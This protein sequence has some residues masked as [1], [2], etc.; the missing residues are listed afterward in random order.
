MSLLEPFR[1][2]WIK[3]S[4]LQDFNKKLLDEN[5]ILLEEIK[6]LKKLLYGIELDI[7]KLKKK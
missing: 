5:K 3:N 2:L 4:N 1:R 6:I 7:T